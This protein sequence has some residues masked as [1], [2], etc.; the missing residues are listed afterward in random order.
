MFQIQNS[1]AQAESRMEEA[2]VFG[3]LHGPEPGD[4][5]HHYGLLNTADLCSHFPESLAF[6]S[7]KETF[8][9]HTQS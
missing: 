6:L 5:G 3:G 2:G 1:E 7:P 4:R 8:T 9:T